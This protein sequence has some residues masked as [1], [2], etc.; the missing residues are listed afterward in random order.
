MGWQ[1]MNRRAFWIGVSAVLCTVWFARAHVLF[2]SLP[3]RIPIHFGSEG[4]T[5]AAPTL[6]TWMI[7]PELAVLGLI[8][9]SVL[10]TVAGEFPQL[11]NGLPPEWRGDLPPQDR[12]TLRRY[13]QR[14]IAQLSLVFTVVLLT[15]HV[16]FGYSAFAAV[17]ADEASY[18]MPTIS[19]IG[20]G[21]AILFGAIAPLILMDV[22]MPRRSTPRTA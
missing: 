12:D 1:R 5:W 11:I 3:P 14:L 18:R 6:A 15:A 10:G 17:G 13:V 2:A 8:A 7:L 19:V 9:F 22:Q 20:L 16:S 4:V 21:V